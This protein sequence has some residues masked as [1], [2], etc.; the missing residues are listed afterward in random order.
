M[1]QISNIINGWKNYLG[2]ETSEQ[3]IERAKVCFDCKYAKKGKFEVV[4]KDYSLKQIKGKYCNV[5][6]CPI[7]TAVRSENKKCPKGKW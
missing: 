2:G 4:L 1:G 3:A 6:K 7:S 5:C